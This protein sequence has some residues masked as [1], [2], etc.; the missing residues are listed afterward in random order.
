MHFGLSASLFH[1][2]CL[3][4]CSML[5]VLCVTA[6]FVCQIA[7]KMFCDFERKSYQCESGFGSKL[8]ENK[9]DVTKPQKVNEILEVEPVCQGSCQCVLLHPN[10]MK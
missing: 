5:L 4:F 2:L 10:C 3:L 8:H 1:R 7:S 6:V 9:K